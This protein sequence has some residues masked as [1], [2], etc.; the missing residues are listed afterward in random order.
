MEVRRHKMK[1]R[2]HV[3]SK[4][5]HKPAFYIDADKEAV[6]IKAVT[7]SF[8]ALEK[9]QAR[10]DAWYKTRG[11]EVKKDSL[12]DSDLFYRWSGDKDYDELLHACYSSGGCGVDELIEEIERCQKEKL[13]AQGLSEEEAEKEINPSPDFD[14][15]GFVEDDVEDNPA[16]T[17]DDGDFAP[18][19]D[20]TATAL[21]IYDVKPVTVNYVATK[22]VKAAASSDSAY[23]KGG[24]GKY[25]R[26]KNVTDPGMLLGRNFSGDP[27]SIINQMDTGRNII[28]RGIVNGIE[29][30]PLK[31]GTALLQGHI[32]D[33]TN[34]IH[35]TKFMDSEDE[36]KVLASALTGFGKFTFDKNIWTFKDAAAAKAK[37]LLVQGN[38]IY[39][40]RFEH[41]Y[42]FDLRSAKEIKVENVR[43]E[44]REDSRVE[45]HL[46]TRM[47]DKD[48]LVDV[49][50]LISRVKEWGHPAVAITDHGVVQ[51]FPLAQALAAEKG[52]KIIY[53]MEGYLVDDDNMSK[54]Y[55][56]ILLAKNMVGLRNLYK[57][58]TMSHL[59]YYKRRP[60]L[61]RS[62]IEDYREGLLLGSACVLGE[63][64]QNIIAGASKERLLE[65]A[66][67]YDYLEIQPLCNNEFLVRSQKV[68]DEEALIDMDKTIIE[69]GDALQKPVVATCDVHFLDPEDK[70]YRE[71]ML[72]AVG[73]KDAKYQPDLYLRT[74]DEMLKEF[75]YLGEEKAYEVVVTNSRR[76]NDSIE[77]IKPLPDGTYSPKI[78]GAEEALSDM[79]YKKAKRIYGD[80]LP[81]VVQDRLDYEL[82]NIIGHGFA[83]LYYIAHKLVKKSLDDGYLVG[84]R[85][86]V[87]SS[88]VATMADITEVNPLPPH[89]IC[90]KC[91]HSEFFLKGEY[92]GGFDLPRKKCPDCG[93]EMDM[94]GHDIPFAIFMGF[95]GDKVPDI[96][97]NFS[98]DYQPRA[99]KYTEEL[100][101]RDNVFRAGTI[102]TIAQKTAVGYARKYAEVNGLQVRKGFLE[103]LAEGVAGVKNTTG[104][105]PGGIVVCPR[106]MDIHEFTPVQ[107][108]ANKKDSGIITTHFDFHSFEGR[109]TKLDILGHDDPT[110]IRMLEDITGVDAKTIPFDDKKVL[111]LFSSTEAIGLT[112][113]QLQGDKVASLAVPECGTS[114]VRRML[115]DSK[116]QCF[117]DVV[118]I[119]GFSHGTN[120]WLDNAQTLIKDGTC[121]LNEAISTRDD[122]MNYLLHRD[123]TPLTC[124]SVMENVRKGRGIEKKNKQGE[125]IT[126]Y[127]E[128]MREGGVPE[129]FITACKKIG[130]LFPRAHAVA[131][132]MMA[133]RIAW[134]KINYPLAFYAA[135]FSIRAKA[136][137]VRV[138][139]GTIEEQLAEFKRLRRLEDEHK[140]GPRD[141]DMIS[142]LEVSM[143]MV[144]RGYQF[145][146][147][148]LLHSE[149]KRFQIRDGKLLPPL[150]AVDSLG[151]KV[152]LSIISEREK[153]PFVSIKEL[154]QRCKVSQTIIETM[155]ELDC[156]DGLPEDAQMSLFG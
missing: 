117:S 97:L 119:S 46:H 134:F 73:M 18:F 102:G 144:Q 66:S 131:Y 36:A 45:L 71:I 83:V 98:G 68:P 84:S 15:Y 51:T 93:T 26:K 21:P 126:N 114:F 49:K 24:G 61:P 150:L 105:H 153:R 63:L 104:Q 151:E 5:G 108:P 90:P 56:I 145:S 23:G 22:P 64:M 111:S 127:E 123:I 91:K 69:L 60:C 85:G 25:R 152:A 37:H 59:C 124:F 139:Q 95:N 44:D 87:G 41:D 43:T 80:P 31:S 54:R 129:W 16:N 107:Y 58:T 13:M 147:V 137:D 82:S 3:V 28:F 30:R 154:Q 128:Q 76:I 142:A 19:A 88:F 103:R 116:P 6:A 40:D 48:A 57:L 8:T 14:T 2:Y 7:H 100:F 12:A 112:P 94:N 125:P 110:I 155:R 38:V 42:V 34:S 113:E 133:F 77:D 106:D 89:Y 81:K 52:V 86:S 141:K 143:E 70:V 29:I 135:Y 50:E 78:E 79:C 132:V 115:E 1:V 156:L 120:V 33:K 11:I 27:V 35:F 72:T 149:A 92:A 67:F 47:S 101:G 32:V 9:L 140:A 65:I 39:D 121:K 122:V 136:F 74:T 99:H 146:N 4:Q 75:S 20:S 118:R 130:Y 62:V 109:I 10:M 96:D 55:H 148:S 138:M 17:F 53:G